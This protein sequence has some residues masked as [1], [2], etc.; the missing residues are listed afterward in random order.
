MNL[1]ESIFQI[2]VHSAKFTNERNT[3]NI[4]AAVRRYNITHPVVND[5]VEAM[6]RALQVYCWPT[7]YVLG[8]LITSLATVGLRDSWIS[9]NNCIS[10]FRPKW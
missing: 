3:E 9:S 4:E 1:Y 7:I 8:T 6:W 2:G 10:L 5:N